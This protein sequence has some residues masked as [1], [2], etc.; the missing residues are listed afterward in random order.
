MFEVSVVWV[1]K[2]TLEFVVDVDVITDDSA[3]GLVVG[4]VVGW[5]VG[6]LYI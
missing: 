2:S 4:L 5:L 3:V 1:W 6:S